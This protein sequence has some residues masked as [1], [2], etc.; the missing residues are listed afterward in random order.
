[1]L[2]LSFTKVTDSEGNVLLDGKV[3]QEESKKQVYKKSTAYLLTNM[4]VE[5]VQRGT[6]TGAKISGM[7]VAGKTGTNNDY[8]AI[9]FTGFTPYY[10]ATVYIGHDNNA[11]LSNAYAGS[12]A[13][14]L[15]SSFMSKIHKGLSDKPIIDASAEELGL[16]EVS[17]C[18]VTGL[19][20]TESCKADINGDTPTSNYTLKGSVPTEE[21]NAHK[22]VSVCKDTLK[23]A[24]STCPIEKQIQ[25]TI[26]E[27]TDKVDD[28]T[29]NTYMKKLNTQYPTLNLNSSCSESH[30]VQDITDTTTVN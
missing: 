12:Y 29:Y 10:S 11:S 26:L 9:G 17:V 1:M 13:A 16:V 19:R 4:L 6:G 14:P 15:W 30:T 21:C 22:T 24:S 18:K 27:K 20:A 5:A 8:R 23:M 28:T 2:P 3:L 7:T 25:I